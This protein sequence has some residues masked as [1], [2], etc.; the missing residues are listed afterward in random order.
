[1]NKQKSK[2]HL[3]LKLQKNEKEESVEDKYL[4][5]D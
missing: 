3:D 4:K 1:M 5:V 2:E